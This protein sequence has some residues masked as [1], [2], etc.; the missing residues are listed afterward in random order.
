VTEHCKIFSGNHL[1]QFEAEVKHDMTLLMMMD[2]NK[3]PE[4]LHHQG[5]NNVK[6]FPDD[7]DREGL[8]NI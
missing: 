2:T 4:T 7:R 5:G 8:Q 1:Q 6:S 3:V